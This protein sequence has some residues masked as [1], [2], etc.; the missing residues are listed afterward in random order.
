MCP[1]FCNT[2]DSGGQFDFIQLRHIPLRKVYL[3]SSGL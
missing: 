2:L 1:E 3:D